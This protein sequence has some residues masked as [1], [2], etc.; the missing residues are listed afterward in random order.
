MID[1]LF[2]PT[3]TGVKA[4]IPLARIIYV[5]WHINEW[6]VRKAEFQLEE[7]HSLT[8]EGDKATEGVAAYLRAVSGGERYTESVIWSSCEEASTDD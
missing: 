4:A 6:G 5:R 3:N 1:H 8:L 7:G 2:I